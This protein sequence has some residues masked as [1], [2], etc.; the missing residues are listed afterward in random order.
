MNIA[1]F[2]TDYSEN[3]ELDTISNIIE[4]FK[5]HPNILKIKDNVKIETKFQ[6]LSVKEYNKRKPTTFNNIPTRFLVENND[7][8]SPVITEMYN[9]AKSNACFPDSLKLADITPAFKKDDRTKK[10]HYRPVSVLP[11]V[12]KIFQRNMY[13]QISLYMESYLSPF[14]CGFRKGLSTQ[15]CIMGM[16]EKWSGNIAGAVFTDLSKAFDCL[17]H[18]LLV[19]KLEAYGFDFQ[20]LD[21]IYSYLSHRKQRTKVNKTFSA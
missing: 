5:N 11:F 14:L 10:D 6:F 17:G 15:Y 9:E 18:E 3:T 21:Y 20:S 13:D 7:I 12:S 19:A 1:R 8:I 16:L 2:V 4:R